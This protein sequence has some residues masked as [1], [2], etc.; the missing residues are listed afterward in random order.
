GE[1]A[2]NRNGLSLQNQQLQGS[3]RELLN[4]FSRF[5]NIVNYL[6]DLSDQMLVTVSS[7]GVMGSRSGFLSVVG[8]Q[9]SGGS[10]L[11]HWIMDNGQRTTDKSDFDSLEMDSY[12]IVHSRIQEILEELVQLEEAV[13]DIVL[14]AKKSDR[15]LEQ[16][17]QMLT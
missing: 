12:G 11:P 14:F 8:N 6:Q 4:R 2:I 16:Q 3:V 5:Q 9:W 1:L 13:E 15:T 7:S 10:R 17:R